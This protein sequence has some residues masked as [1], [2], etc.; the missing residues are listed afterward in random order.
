M[1]D[2]RINPNDAT[3]D[4]E[5]GGDFKLNQNGG[6]LLANGWNQIRQR[7]LRRL[8]TNPKMVL[9]G[10]V[11]VSADYIYHQDYGCGLKRKMG[12]PF[13]ED[14]RRQ[15]ESII[16][17]AVLDDEGVNTSRPPLVNVT[18]KDDRVYITVL[19]FLKSGREGTVVFS[20][21]N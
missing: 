4:L 8:F 7:I 14:T 17:N 1:A 2:A 10:N 18:Q 5:P 11:P 15:L 20:Y 3:L 16:V 21:Q 19:V 13:N 12:E 6:L 9:S